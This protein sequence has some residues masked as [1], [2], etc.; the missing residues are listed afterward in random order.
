MS[1]FAIKFDETGAAFSALS[2][3]TIEHGLTEHGIVEEAKINETC[4]ADN[5]KRGNNSIQMYPAHKKTESC[6]FVKQKDF[7]NEM[8]ENL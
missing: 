3:G 5:K 6:K 7:E 4:S 8:K 1:C 2:S